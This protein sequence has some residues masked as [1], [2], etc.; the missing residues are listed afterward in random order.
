MALESIE[1]WPNS[2]HTHFHA[3][4]ILVKDEVEWMLHYCSESTK[5]TA[6][7]ISQLYPLYA[8]S[9][10]RLPKTGKLLPF[11]AVW[12]YIIY[13]CHVTICALVVYI[14]DSIL[15][16]TVMK[17]AQNMYIREIMS[18]LNPGHLSQKLGHLSQKLVKETNAKIIFVN[19]Y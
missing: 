16:V 17:P 3:H 10:W 18:N 7:S 12:A 13:D 15:S 9:C 5:A 6:E 11:S 8:A 1:F 4:R 2:S 14:F 19:N